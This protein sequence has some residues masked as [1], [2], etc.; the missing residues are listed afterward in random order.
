MY[1]AQKRLGNKWTTIAALLPGR[2]MNAIKDRWH[3]AKMM[4]R[5]S[6]GYEPSTRQDS[7]D[8]TRDAHS[9]I[10]HDAQKC[11]GNKWTTIA[12]LLPG[13]SADSVRERYVN[14]LEDGAYTHRAFRMFA[15]PQVEQESC[16]S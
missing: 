1:D 7:V 6:V 5:A 9:V 16:K 4:Q 3:N 14:H 13:Q 12:A 15:L 2:S 8:R 10:L 11:L